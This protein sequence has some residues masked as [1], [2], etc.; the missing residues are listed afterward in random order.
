MYADE[1]SIYIINE[2]V[3]RDTGVRGFAVARVGGRGI[4]VFVA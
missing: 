4:V 1:K 2:Y 3:S